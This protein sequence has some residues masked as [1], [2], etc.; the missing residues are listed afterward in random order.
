MELIGVG[1]VPQRILLFRSKWRFEIELFLVGLAGCLQ[2][3]LLKIQT[4]V[5]LKAGFDCFLVASLLAFTR[6][7]I[8]HQAFIRFSDFEW[9]CSCGVSLN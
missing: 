6:N 2:S 8:F 1:R 4:R 3:F 9:E 5:D 7:F